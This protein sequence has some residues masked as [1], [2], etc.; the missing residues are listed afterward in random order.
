MIKLN[1]GAQNPLKA[2]NEARINYL[3]NALNQAVT[4]NNK[5]RSEYRNLATHL[6]GMIKITNNQR[7]DLALK[8][9]AYGKADTNE[10][11]LRESLMDAL[12][13]KAMYY[14]A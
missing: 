1:S 4:V 9:I 6:S 12:H 14:N 10:D 2:T 11:L 3:S 7:S 8:Q 13:S 5:A